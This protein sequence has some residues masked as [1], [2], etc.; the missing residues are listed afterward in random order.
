M[1]SVSNLTELFVRMSPLT[2][3]RIVTASNQCSTLRPTTLAFPA[4]DAP[5]AFACPA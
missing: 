2:T 4:L 5:A 3:P 1:F